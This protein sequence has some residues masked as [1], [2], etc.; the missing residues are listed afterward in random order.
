MSTLWSLFK[1]VKKKFSILRGFSFPALRR[2]PSE[3]VNSNLSQNQHRGKNSENSE[4]SENPSVDIPFATKVTPNYAWDD[5]DSVLPDDKK[6]QLKGM[7][8]DIR[9]GV[10]KDVN[11]GFERKYFGEGIMVLLSGGSG[12]VKTMVAEAIAGGLNFNLYRIDLSMVVSKYIGETEK[13]LDIIFEKAEGSELILFFDEADALFGKRSEIKEAH[14]RYANTEI[15]YV[16]QKAESNEGITILAV[17]QD[18]VMES[19]LRRM[20]YI[21]DLSSSA[22]DEEDEDDA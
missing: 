9:Y 18:R 5:L 3:V 6:E 22:E 20:H 7:F 16:L 10:N 15:D 19:L 4:N 21:I 13:N 14:H 8:S 1:R 2:E 12:N 11:N 17:D